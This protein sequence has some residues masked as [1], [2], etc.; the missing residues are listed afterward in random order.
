MFERT[1]FNAL[2]VAYEINTQALLDLLFYRQWHLPNS[3]MVVMILKVFTWK[4][5]EVLVQ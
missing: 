2:V 5:K 3:I 1:K 4:M